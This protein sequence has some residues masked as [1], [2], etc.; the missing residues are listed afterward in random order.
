MNS[1]TTTQESISLSSEEYVNLALRFSKAYGLACAAWRMPGSNEMHLI[2]DFQGARKMDEFILEEVPTGFLLA[3]FDNS[4]GTLHINSD[5]HINLTTKEVNSFSSA[6][7]DKFNAY[8]QQE[9]KKRNPQRSTAIRL[10]Q[11][12]LSEPFIEMV[13]NAIEEIRLG[14]FQKVVPS[15]FKNVR[16]NPNFDHGHFFSTLCESYPNAFVSLVCTPVSGLWIGASPELLLELKANLFKTVSLAGTQKY[17]GQSLTDVA[18]TQK[19][20]EEQALVSRYIINGFKKIRLREFDENGPR[21]VKAGNLIHLKTEFIVDMASTN[22]YDLG[23]VMLNLLHP[24]SAIC[25]MPLEPS[26]KFI[27]QHENYPREYFS[28]YLGPV[29]FDH[30][31]SLFVNLRCM[32]I[33]NH[34]ATL[35]AGA[36][37]TADSNPEKEWQETEMK[38]NTLLNL[39]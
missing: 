4:Q 19:E 8:A 31:T 39:I 20:I 6:A 17:E 36:G 11:P 38:M 3:P 22:F 14:S 13:N 37:I 10:T 24:T 33:E 35:Y 15:R 18:W 21:T 1:L 16:L 32:K 30:K 25:G 28:G 12:I 34:M 27:Q 7:L 26:L 23:S 2:L 5:I 9:T 29:D